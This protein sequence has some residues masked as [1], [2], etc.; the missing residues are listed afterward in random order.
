MAQEIVINVQLKCNKCRSKA[1]S[2]AAMTSGVLSVALEGEKKDQLV[3]IGVGVDA[4]GM[5]SLLRKKVGRASL[6]LVHDNKR[7][8][9][10][11]YGCNRFGSGGRS[12]SPRQLRW[13]RKIVKRG[14]QS[15][16][17][18]IINFA[19]KPKE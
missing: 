10:I 17:T 12:F 4:A 9:I 6:E 5:T 7:V 2:I 3:V 16:K 18:P 1:M 15:I 19:P 8:S 11:L 14:L 13:V